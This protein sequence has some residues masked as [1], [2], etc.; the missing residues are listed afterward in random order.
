MCDFQALWNHLPPLISN[1]HSHSSFLIPLPLFIQANSPVIT[2]DVALTFDALA[3][4]P[5]PYVKHFLTALG[6]QGLPKLLVGFSNS[7]PDSEN[8]ATAL[9]TF[10]YCPGPGKEV[11][12]F[13]GKTRGRIVEPRGPRDFGWDCAFEAEGTGKT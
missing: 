6:P 11:V 2:E 9:C 7:D 3:P 12:L 5:G 4:L 1:F 8:G 10:A 13:E